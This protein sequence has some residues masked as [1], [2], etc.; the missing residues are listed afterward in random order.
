M[1]TEP[2]VLLFNSTKH[3]RAFVTPLMLAPISSTFGTDLLLNSDIQFFVAIY[4]STNY[5]SL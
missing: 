2:S 3:T 4:A 1:P 5:A